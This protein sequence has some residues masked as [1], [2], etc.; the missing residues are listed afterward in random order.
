[1]DEFNQVFIGSPYTIR[2][3]QPVTN[4]R[5]T[6]SV[7][8]RLSTGDCSSCLSYVKRPK[9]DSNC[10]KLSVNEVDSIKKLS[11]EYVNGNNDAKLIKDINGEH[12]A[13]KVL[14]CLKQSRQRYRNV[15]IDFL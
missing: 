14:N 1:M 2:Q 9:L 3:C 7:R 11:M 10:L 8:K 13:S 15:I 5:L 6:R 12:F 4:L